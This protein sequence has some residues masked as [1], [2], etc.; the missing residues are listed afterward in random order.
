MENCNL[1]ELNFNLEKQKGCF[2][3]YD[4]CNTDLGLIE[5]ISKIINEKKLKKIKKFITAYHLD[6]NSLFPKPLYNLNNG[7]LF[8]YLISKGKTGKFLF[9]DLQG[10]KYD[11]NYFHC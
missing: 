11:I 6:Y 8:R 7:T 3:L 1:K 2:V 4:N 10:I 5:F 9:N